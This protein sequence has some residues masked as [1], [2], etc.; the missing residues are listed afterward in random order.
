MRRFTIPKLGERAI[1][2]FIALLQDTL[3]KT[4]HL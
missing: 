1:Q 3:H 4:P 2:I